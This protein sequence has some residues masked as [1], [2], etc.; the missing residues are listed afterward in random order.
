MKIDNY[1]AQNIAKVSQ[2]SETQ[3]SNKKKGD[4]VS[5]ESFAS[6][7]ENKLQ[8]QG[9]LIFS[10]HAQ[11]RISQRDIVLSE[12]QMQKLDSAVK[13]AGQQG[14]EDTLVLMDKMAFII[15]VSKNT[16][17]TAMRDQDIEGNV[18]KQIDGAVI[19]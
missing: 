7:F 5:G 1:L 13:K 12:S 17:I 16:V 14:V 9:K 8:E 15:N 2:N 18:F 19:I 4:G 3:L 11:Q 6:I 10:K